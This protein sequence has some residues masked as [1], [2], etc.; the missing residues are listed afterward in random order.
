MIEL[1]SVQNIGD[2]RYGTRDY[3]EEAIKKIKEY[4]SKGDQITRTVKE[5]KKSSSPDC[6]NSKKMSIAPEPFKRSMPKI[7]K[8]RK[9]KQRVR[10]LS[11]EDL[12]DRTK[13]Y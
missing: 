12:K 7:K 8:K 1:G 4:Y 5:V 6:Q 10:S 13:F 2:N 9:R 11:Q 3:D